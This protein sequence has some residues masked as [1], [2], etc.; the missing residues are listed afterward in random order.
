MWE[1]ADHEYGAAEAEVDAAAL[2]NPAELLARINGLEASNL[3]LL[4]L[5]EEQREL[6][7]EL[8]AVLAER[9]T[10][11]ATI[12]QAQDAVFIHPFSEDTGDLYHGYRICSERVLYALGNNS[13]VTAEE[14]ET[15]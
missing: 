15:L 7:A 13:P 2:R 6:K 8:S 11:R 1:P 5:A 4:A 9:D 14:T 3:H 10:L 12:K